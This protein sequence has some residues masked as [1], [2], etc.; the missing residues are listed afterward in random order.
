[1]TT[2]DW[3]FLG[4]VDYRLVLE[5]Q[6]D[7][8]RRVR[9][10][11]NPCLFFVEHPPS[12]TLG[13]AAQESNL[14]MSEEQYAALGFGVHRI[15]RGGDV[16]YHGPGQLVGY[17]V[18]CLDS[19][20][21]SVG[22]WVRGI[23]ESIVGFLADHGINACWLD[24]TPGVWV[25]S[26]KIAALGFHISR[27]ISTHG[28]ALNLDPDLSHYETI[29]PCG[30][31]EKGVTSMAKLGAHVPDMFQAASSLANHVAA[32][33]HWQL[34]RFSDPRQ[35]IERANLLDLVPKCPRFLG[36]ASKK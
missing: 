20:A 21:C 7:F 3:T 26:D 36:G 10:G 16:T 27:R 13:R 17:P 30:L 8:A 34:G 35:F 11:A 2:L 29:I 12:I 32:R 24:D 18:A 23:A 33:F 22:E 4:R 31:K 9:D 28:L 25:D 5:L 15:L 14:K 19:C 1:M 6:Y